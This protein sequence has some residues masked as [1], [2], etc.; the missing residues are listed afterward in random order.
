M[1]SVDSVPFVHVDLFGGHGEVRVWNLLSGNAE[2]FTAVLFCELAA[3]G[4]VGRHVQEQFPEMVI[5]LGGS[6]EAV[7]NGTVHALGQGSAVF[8]PLGSVLSLANR[9]ETEPLRYLI[10]KAR[11][12]SPQKT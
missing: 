8:L 1:A 12:R 2:P 10:V 7:V 5:G 6:G 11:G 3:G 4:S 9:S